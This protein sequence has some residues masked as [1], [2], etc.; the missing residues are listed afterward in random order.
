MKKQF[1]IFVL[2][3]LLLT[4]VGC[5]NS[6][7]PTAGDQS[8]QAQNSTLSTSTVQP[9]IDPTA[10]TK[11]DL[12][13]TLPSGKIQLL[14]QAG[15]LRIPYTSDI[16]SV[17]YITDPS[18]LPDHDEFDQYD[19]AF[20]EKNALLLITE[21]VGSGSTR[22]DLKGYICEENIAR[23]TLLFSSPDVATDDMATWLIWAVVDA[24]LPY[25]WSINGK[26]SNSNS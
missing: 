22:I 18:Q 15:K 8:T 7:M 3:G 1:A 4:A 5:Q 17:Q 26:T 24:N 11:P 23:V 14:E 19:A 21:T 10:S 13:P 12:T 2:T 25:E 16:H 20:F 6:K 9:N